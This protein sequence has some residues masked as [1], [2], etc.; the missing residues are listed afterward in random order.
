MRVRRAFARLHGA[1]DKAFSL[2]LVSLA[3]L[4]WMLAVH[5][6]GESALTHQRLM[7]MSASFRGI[8][9]SS[10]QRSPAGLGAGP[11]VA[12]TVLFGTATVQ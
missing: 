4:Q 5:W 12:A 8:G 3:G 2:V 11:V 9:H 7:G 6:A 10:G 1:R